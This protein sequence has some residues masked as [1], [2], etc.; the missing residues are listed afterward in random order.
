MFF[1]FIWFLF[2]L[3]RNFF[4]L[5]TSISEY[6]CYCYS[7]VLQTATERN[8]WSHRKSIVFQLCCIYIYV[9]YTIKPRQWKPNQLSPS[10]SLQSLCGLFYLLKQYLF[11][12]VAKQWWSLRNCSNSYWFNK[13]QYYLYYIWSNELHSVSGKRRQY[14]PFVR[15][16]HFN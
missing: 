8:S 2:H 3:Q 7:I 10:V 6:Y 9:L 15:E 4:Y 12:L 16:Y 11:E 14:C 1:L 13:L 5:S